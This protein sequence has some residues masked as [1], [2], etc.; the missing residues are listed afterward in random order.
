MDKLPL[1]SIIIPVYNRLAELQAC[2]G[3]VRR[4]NYSNLEII[5]VDDCS[6]QDPMAAVSAQFPAVRVLRHRQNAGAAQSRNDGARA[7]RGEYLFFL[8]SDTAVHPELIRELVRSFIN[9]PR[10]GLVAPMIYYHGERQR[11]WYA[12]ATVSLLTSQAHYRG[13]NEWDRGQFPVGVLVNGHA[14]TAAMVRADI[15]QRIG[16]F[17]SSPDF[18][19]GF[20]EPDLAKR[21]EKA[22]FLIV[23][24]PRAKLWH[25]IPVPKF[26]GHSAKEFFYYISF[27]NPKIAYTTSRNRVTYMRRY[28]PKLNYFIFR[29]I[30]L[31]L[32][33]AIYWLK[34]ACSHQPEMWQ[35]IRQGTCDALKQTNV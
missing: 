35:S 22:G 23:F 12:G 8:D 29:L 18:Y 21:I 24:N 26:Q 19:M 6:S 17:D 34:S 30:F 32:S 5:V 10:A 3:S 25:K 2:L 15:F 4:L 9:F 14:P 13:I 7:A 31:P 20:E 27:R 33:L 11:I 28:A 16:G 1:V